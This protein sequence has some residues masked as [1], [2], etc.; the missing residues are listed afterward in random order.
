MAIA[1]GF[2]PHILR[3]DL[4]Q[5]T[6]TKEALPPEEDLR[7]YLGGIGLGLL[8]LLR[9]APPKGQATDP[10]VPLIFMNGP[11][12]GTPAVNSSDVTIVSFHNCTPYSAKSL[13]G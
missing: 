2:C 9:E 4:N 11:L 6:I 13:V 3:V 10:D 12:T 5:E 7:K 1:G 8:Y